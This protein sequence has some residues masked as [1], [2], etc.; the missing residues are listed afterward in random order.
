MKSQ[1][2]I[3]HFLPEMHTSTQLGGVLALT[4]EVPLVRPL[5]IEEGF[6]FFSS[7]TLVLSS[8]IEVP[9]VLQGTQIT[10]GLEHL[11]PA[12]H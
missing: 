6:I 3:A 5:L 2:D 10:L 11:E 7:S 9:V 1:L 4:V 8:C 12:A